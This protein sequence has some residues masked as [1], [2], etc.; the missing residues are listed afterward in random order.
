MNKVLFKHELKDAWMEPI[1]SI[2]IIDDIK[3]NVIINDHKLII[4]SNAIEDLKKLLNN[5]KLYS[6][7][8]VLFPPI[9]DGTYHEILLSNDKS[10][11][12]KCLNLWYWNKKEISNNCR[13]DDKPE[14]IEY[15][16][17]V[18][19]LIRNIQKIL[20]KNNIKF[21]ILDDRFFND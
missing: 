8:H 2:S 21:Y 6:N 17:L 15:T 10:K 13:K 19:D 16:Q 7:G 11:R 1:S 3:Y 5:D 18:I 12:I 20:N 9:L 4:S 14:D